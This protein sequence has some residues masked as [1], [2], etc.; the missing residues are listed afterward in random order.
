MSEL[1]IAF[2]QVFWRKLTY[3][4][5]WLYSTLD[6]TAMTN[7][8]Q[9]KHIYITNWVIIGVDNGLLP[10]RHQ[11]IIWTNADLLSIGLLRTNCSEVVIAVQ[12]LKVLRYL[13][14]PNFPLGNLRLKNLRNEIENVICKI[15]FVPV[16][17][18]W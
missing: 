4:E 10:I 14:I 11:A 6:V 2:L 9:V 12:Q 15:H 8:D 16:A 7:W 1:W 5:V 18:M 13:V 3:D 17:R